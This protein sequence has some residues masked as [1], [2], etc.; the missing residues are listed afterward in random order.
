MRA[1]I[2]R[3]RSRKLNRRVPRI[4]SSFCMCAGSRIHSPKASL[5]PGAKNEGR[6]CPGIVLKKT[7]IFIGPTQIAR[8]TADITVFPP[9][10]LGSVFQAV[11]AGFERIAIVDGYFGNSPSI[12]HKEILFALSAGIEVWGAGSIGALRAAEL[13]SFGMRGVGVIF[14][15][16]L[17]GALTD[18]DEVC[19]MHGP[20]EL[21]YV[22]TTVPMINV[23]GT[24]R[25][26]RRRNFITTRTELELLPQLKS[27]HFSTRTKESVQSILEATRPV[28]PQ[29]WRD[30]E[31]CYMDIKNND[32]AALLVRLQSRCWLSSRP[33]SSL[34]E[35]PETDHWR[36]Q[37][38]ERVAEI[39][40]LGEYIGI[41]N[42]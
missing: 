7:C 29:I 30:Y 39:P 14:R 13:A 1:R 28:S 41:I 38:E 24:L 8:D 26:M 33:A 37:F 3:S 35:F 4:T 17:R 2:G 10:S 5:L 18:D 19:L 34:W 42:R 31:S 23:R 15:L 16:Y 12:W 20:P 6:I 27:I 22:P 9:A 11:K 32:A 21:S 40:S 36:H 25:R